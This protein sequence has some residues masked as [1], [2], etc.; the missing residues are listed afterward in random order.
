VQSLHQYGIA[1]NKANTVT[2]MP[3]LLVRNNLNLSLQTTAVTN[4]SGSAVFAR[5]VLAKL[6]I[7]V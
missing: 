5:T 4:V 1:L 6:G 3:N 2:K 7:V